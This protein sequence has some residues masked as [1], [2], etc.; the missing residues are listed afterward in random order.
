M[1]LS[2]APGSRLRGL[3]CKVTL[4]SDAVFVVSHHKRNPQCWCWCVTGKAS[5]LVTV[6]LQCLP[7]TSRFW[8]RGK[9]S[10]K[11]KGSGFCFAWSLW[12]FY[13][14]QVFL[15]SLLFA[16]R[17][18]TLV[19]QDSPVVSLAWVFPNLLACEG[20]L[21]FNGWPL[22]M[23]VRCILDA[24]WGCCTRRGAFH[25]QLLIYGPFDCEEADCHGWHDYPMD[26]I[27]HVVQLE[28]IEM[29]CRPTYK[30]RWCNKIN[31]QSEWITVHSWN[32]PHVSHR[33]F[34]S[35]K[36]TSYNLVL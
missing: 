25:Q 9:W 6:Y 23:S 27:W 7:V 13:P 4:W 1:D 2:L 35:L 33:L 16:T 11:R 36:I 5:W 18:S 34:M 31:R 29:L 12:W 10:V 21:T 24:L 14:P 22:M 19:F 26:I 32:C 28:T 3:W 17:R 30:W 15:F 8:Q 20:C